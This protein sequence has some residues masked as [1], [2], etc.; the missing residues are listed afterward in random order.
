MRGCLLLLSM[1]GCL[2]VLGVPTQVRVLPCD[3][4]L[5]RVLDDTEETIRVTED[6]VNR[7]DLWSG[8]LTG[9]LQGI[10]FDNIE[11]GGDVVRGVYTHSYRHD[12]R[13]H[14]HS[15]G[16]AP[17]VQWRDVLTH[18]LLHHMIWLRGEPKDKGHDRHEI[19]RIQHWVRDY[20]KLRDKERE[21]QNGRTLEGS[22]QSP[23]GEIR[24][25]ARESSGRPG[26]HEGRVGAEGGHWVLDHVH[27]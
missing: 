3:C 24:G 17:G 14:A 21:V 26:A 25:D 8:G 18:E 5:D 6:L 10:Y 4:T 2:E 16:V 22:H 7:M 9:K 13:M 1:C 23:G 12:K 11:V 20:W 19:W 27:D 15:V